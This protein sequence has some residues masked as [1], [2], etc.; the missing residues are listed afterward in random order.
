MNMS[1]EVSQT[2]IS[3]RAL[4]QKEESIIFQRV[5]FWI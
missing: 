5:Q 2:S 1:K 3:Q 4:M